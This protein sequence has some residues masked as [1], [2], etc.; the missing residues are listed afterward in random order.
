LSS[1]LHKVLV[2]GV[3]ER[4]IANLPAQLHNLIALPLADFIAVSILLSLR[5]VIECC[6]L[7]GEGSGGPKPKRI[8]R[9]FQ[10]G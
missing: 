5:G 1:L 6:G 2:E 3:D 8:L 9:F 4:V 10:S 7:G